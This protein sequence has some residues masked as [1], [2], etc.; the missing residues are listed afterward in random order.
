VHLAGESNGSD[1]FAGKIRTPKGLAN[2]DACGAPPVLGLLL[3]PANLGSRKRLMI[4]RC[5]RNE[6]PVLVDDD[7]ACAAGAN[8]NAKY[9]DKASSTASSQLS[10][11]IIYSQVKMTRERQA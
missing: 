8:V 11:D 5:G 1:V 9:V 4:C 6:P 3:R 10:G 7:G 2:S